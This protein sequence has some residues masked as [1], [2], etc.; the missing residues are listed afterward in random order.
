M[1]MRTPS[2]DSTSLAPDSEEARAI[3]VLGH[4]DA[5]GRDDQRGEGRNIIGLQPVAA[6]AD[7]VDGALGRLDRQHPGPHGR[8]RAGHFIQRFAP[9]AQTHQEGA[10]LGRGGLAGQ[11]A[12]ESRFRLGAGQRCAGGDLGE[13]GLE[14]LHGVSGP[15]LGTAFGRVPAFGEIEEIAQQ[16]MAM[17]GGDAFGMELHAMR[18]MGD[19][20]Q[21]HDEAV[22]VWAVIARSVGR[23]SRRT[24][25]EW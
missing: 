5:A 22:G 13:E 18:G 15:P 21:A 2:S 3:A 19:V 14:A 9:G 4:R 17:F 16:R 23:L 1:P 7:N 8:D 24:T 20:A 10:R 6:G 11:Q 12:V 25:S